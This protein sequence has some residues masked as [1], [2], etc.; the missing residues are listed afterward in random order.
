MAR[1]WT[2]GF[3]LQSVAAGVEIL[4]VTGTPTISTSVRRSGAASLRIN[5][6]AATQYVEQQIDSGTVKRTT[7]RFYLRITTLPSADCTIYG[8]GQSGY[9][10]GLL[11]L[12]TTGVLTLRDGFTSADIGTASAALSTGVWYRIELDYT[13]VA[14]TAGSFTGAFRGYI[15]GAVF[16]DTLCSNIN[17]W[18][19]VRLG[20]QTAVT[21]EFHIDDVAV[22]DTTGSAQNGL[23]GPG[24]VTHLRPDSAGDNTGFATTVGGTSNWQRVSEVTPD[25]VTTYNATVATGTTTTDD[26]NLG[27]T[28]TAG[29]SG[30][31]VTLVQVGARIGSNAA[32][33]A[34]LV[35]RI[36]SQ[37]AGTVLESASVS[38]ALNGW[39]SQKAA[40]P[41][42]Y[43]LTSYTDPQAGG[44]WTTALLD[45]AQIG[46]RSNVSQAT[47]R[48]VSA[49][50]ALVE[51][52]PITAQ[53][54]TL[55]TETGAAQALGRRK[56]LALGTATETSTAQTLAPLAGVPFSA[57]TDSFNDNTVDAVKWPD[58]Y[59]PGGYSE[60]GGRARVACNTGYNAY[61]SDAAYRLRES[62]VHVRMWPPA[63]GGAATEAWAQLLVQTVTLG[64][65]AIFEVSAVTGNLIMAVRTGYFDPGQAA[66]PYDATAHAWLR[67]RETGGQLL[68]DTSPDGVTWTNRR[69]ATN[70]AWVGDTTLQV[71]LISHR[72]GGV[73]DFA[74]FD[75]FN[76]GAGQ[77]LAL[78]GAGEADTA[79]ALTGRKT[80]ALGTAAEAG[81]AQV[82]GG[83]KARLLGV[84]AE[85]DTA[86]ALT[87]RKTRALGAAAG[88]DIAQALGHSRSRAL[89]PAGET[90]AAQLLGRGKTASL[91][92][93]AEVAEARALT[94]SRAAALGRAVETAV[95]R[96]LGQAKTG[97]LLPAAATETAQPLTGRKQL[98]LGAAA[99][100]TAARS[101][102]TAKAAV[103]PVAEETATA[104]PLTPA[105]GLVPAE[106]T[107]TAQP[108][109]RVKT[110]TVGVA[111][112]VGEARPLGRAKVRGLTVAAETATARPLTGSRRRALVPA[113]E[114]STARP[115]SWSRARQLPTAVETSEALGLTPVSAGALGV[116]D[117]TDTARPVTGRKT[118]TLAAA[119]V[120][121]V[122]QPVTGRKT[123][124]IGAA[125]ET[126]AARPLT[127]GK[128]AHLAPATELT[129]AQRLLVPGAL[130]AAEEFSTALPLVGG[131]TAALGTAV[132][133][134]EAQQ[135]GA[136]SVLALGRADE[137]ASALPVG[138]HRVRALPAAA[139]LEAAQPLRGTKAC[140]LGRAAEV[141][142]ALIGPQIRLTSAVEHGQALTLTGRRQRPADRLDPSTS[143]PVLTPST[144]GPGLSTSSSGPYLAA[145]STGGG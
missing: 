120:V 92:A 79:Q 117:E 65:D 97:V 55:A 106:E 122:A 68:W 99:E 66:I 96:P 90:A 132:E 67:I 54:L 101:V 141:T 35:Y 75:S 116:A 38:V 25:D 81:S 89:T 109:G 50:W 93:A 124:A 24:N 7:H 69:T 74:E 137:V 39:A 45:Q 140:P 44:A 16:S 10:P 134:A 19:R 21:G 57:L 77:E 114:T 78:T 64:T 43:Q 133:T 40:A 111:G 29:I 61:A 91:A 48:R 85:G 37:T 105:S 53:A 119:V 36:K 26:F 9:F 23:P 6:T 76:T 62:S 1:L 107:S 143:G 27:S 14:G 15:N 71:Q 59:E 123:T 22:N 130:A 139:G 102:G 63:A 95:A 2:C 51:T 129:E 18:S 31:R 13:D 84:V 112:E 41:Y 108:L 115:L 33:A 86:Q 4:S 128:R 103:L 70:P 46:Y 32:T 72:D 126:A 136:Q 20:A 42:V 8:I 98:P 145:S 121:E 82:L 58:S 28:S 142:Q 30:E 88:A 113:E 49:L 144:S 12:K 127:G 11:R 100:S 5:P 73:N 138:R 104:M 110:R 47:A 34:S 135:F 60:T 125:V 87:G 83:R 118:Q 52:V 3:E 17:G 80:R 56:T 131:K 94:G